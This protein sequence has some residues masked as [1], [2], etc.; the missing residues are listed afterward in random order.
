MGRSI[1]P[2]RDTR[3]RQGYPITQFDKD[4]RKAPM[5]SR[6]RTQAKSVCPKASLWPWPGTYNTNSKLLVS[7]PSELLQQTRIINQQRIH[8]SISPPTRLQ[9][10]GAALN[11]RFP[12]ITVIA[13]TSLPISKLAKFRSTD[14][15]DMQFEVLATCKTTR[16]RVS[17]MTLPREFKRS[18]LRLYSSY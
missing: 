17:R 18:K 2:V 15:L 14:Q 11:V 5:R 7:E 9:G 1:L 10:L 12:T 13:A 3:S 6:W 16:A 4:S 8:H